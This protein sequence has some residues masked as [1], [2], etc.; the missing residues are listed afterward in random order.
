MTLKKPPKDE[1]DDDKIDTEEDDEVNKEY[2]NLN[3]LRM[4]HISNFENFGY[5]KLKGKNFTKLIKKFVVILGRTITQQP[6][7]EETPT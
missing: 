1:D 2:Q 6:Q 7:N 3:K 5:A 4:F